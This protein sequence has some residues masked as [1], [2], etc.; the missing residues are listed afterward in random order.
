MMW[1]INIKTFMEP[2]NLSELIAKTD[3]EI[4]RLG[5]NVE[6]G[7][8][9]LIKTYGKRSRVLL[10]EEE[11]L[12]FLRYLEAQPTPLEAQPTPPIE[13]ILI[14]K[15]NTEL[16]RLWWTEEDEH[17]YLTKTYNQPSLTGLTQKELINF[18]RYLKSQ[19]EIVNPY[20]ID[21]D[22]EEFQFDIDDEYGEAEDLDTYT[23]E[24]GKAVN[25]PSSEDIA[26]TDVQ[27][28]RLGLNEQW[29]RDHLVKTYGKRGRY[30]LTEEE[31]LDFLHYLESQPTPIDEST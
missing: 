6:W 30:L 24:L 8:D 22:Y 4:Y 9:Y 29:L 12:E 3:I 28:Q 20:D 26:K 1:S 11:L 19:P 25:K 14:T 27:M 23:E 16:E 7:R 5:W 21:N 17:E 31:L 18:F 2:E 13:E 10:T 15:I